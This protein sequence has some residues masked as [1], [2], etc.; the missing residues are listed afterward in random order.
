MPSRVF[1]FP[2]SW[3]EKQENENLMGMLVSRGKVLQCVTAEHVTEIIGNSE[4]D[5]KRAEQVC[6]F[7]IEL[8]EERSRL[9]ARKGRIKRE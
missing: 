2:A 4:D 5:W 7:L 3:T 6:K 1:E 8:Q 9:E